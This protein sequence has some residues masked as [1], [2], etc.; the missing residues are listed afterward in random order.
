LFYDV[1]F[2][3]VEGEAAAIIDLSRLG[4]TGRIWWT[5]KIETPVAIVV[6]DR[7]E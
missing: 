4:A 5:S 7:D 6:P 1:A 3:L 2:D